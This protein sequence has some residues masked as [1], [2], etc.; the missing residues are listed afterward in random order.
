MSEQTGSWQP[1]P[2]GRNQYRYWDG[3]HWTDQVSNDGVVSTDPAVASAI[4][5]EAAA[6]QAP[7]TP[8]PDPSAVQ[9]A[10]ASSAAA[11]GGG[12]S[13]NPLLIGGV[14]LALVLG[15]GAYFM[16]SGDDDSASRTKLVADLRDQGFPRTQAECIVDE[17]G[18][19]VDLNELVRAIERDDDPTPAQEAA[20]LRGIMECGGAFG[21]D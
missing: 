15:V 10:P 21:R 7:T 11:S 5:T 16:F 6:A 9:P 20:L 4:P 8:S 17:A 14:V 2:F 13:K 3:V 1:D 19:T 18:R 12:G